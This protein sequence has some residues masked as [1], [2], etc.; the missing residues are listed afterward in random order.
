MRLVLAQR[1]GRCT[2]GRM[3]SRGYDWYRVIQIRAPLIHWTPSKR[4]TRSSVKRTPNTA[5][6]L[7]LR[8]NRQLCFFQPDLNYNWCCSLGLARSQAGMESAL[9]S[10]D[11]GQND[12]VERECNLFDL[13]PVDMSL[14]DIGTGQKTTFRR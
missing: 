11:L 8:Y 9:M 14:R 6:L 13:S 1:V 5:P 7:Y 10:L 4:L 3:K 2:G 12:L